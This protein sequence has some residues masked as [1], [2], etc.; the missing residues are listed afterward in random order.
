MRPLIDS[1][2]RSAIPAH[3]PA[4]CTIREKVYT[5]SESN[6]KVQTGTK[7]V[8]VNVECRLAPL[9]QERATNDEN[10]TNMVRQITHRG[11]LKLNGFFPEIIPSEM[12]AVVDGT[13]WEIRGVENDGSN[14]STRLRVEILKP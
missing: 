13:V 4:R 14:F 3:W 10:R 6:Q 5:F 9:I 7:D 12:E 2:L 1:R 11:N 8:I